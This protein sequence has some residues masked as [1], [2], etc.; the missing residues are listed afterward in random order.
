MNLGEDQYRHENAIST[1]K[2]TAFFAGT[3]YLGDHTIKGGIDYQRDKIYNLF[4]R[5]E[6]G[7]YTFYG[8]SD[9]AAGN[10][11]EY[12]LYQPAGGYT[13]NDVAANWVY[14]QYSPFLQDTWQVNNSLSIAYGLRMDIP[15]SDHPPLYNAAFEQAFGYRNNN[16][17]GSKNKVVEPRFS[18][19]YN[20]NTERMT[21][22]RGGI[23]LF[24]TFPPT[25]WMTNP[26]QNNGLTVASYQSFNPSDAAFSPDAYNQNI[27]NSPGSVSGD[28]DT[29]APNFK[30]PTVWKATSGARSR[31]AVVGHD[32]LGRAAA[33]PGPGRHLLPGDQY[34]CA[35]VARMAI[36]FCC[37]MAAISTGP[38]PGETAKSAAMPRPTATRRSTRPR[39]C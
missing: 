4:G 31:V 7:N 26:Y 15:H 10:Y 16:S 2:W 34:R 20:F 32:R 11:H 8:L 37:R 5:T 17:L 6:H 1:K 13:L 25:V 33:H 36:P 14:S 38:L 28:V 12:D 3:L 21:Q 30:L 22:L 24:Q 29:I 39:P 27:P 35:D 19:N 18:F 9:F 23:G